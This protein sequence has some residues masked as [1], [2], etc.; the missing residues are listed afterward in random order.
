MNF[1]HRWHQLADHFA[2]YERNGIKIS[3][4]SQY[5]AIQTWFGENTARHVFECEEW[6]K[7]AHEYKGRYNV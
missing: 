1:S 4:E 5:F 3:R 2:S 7:Q 6:Y